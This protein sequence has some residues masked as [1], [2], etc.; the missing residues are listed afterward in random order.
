MLLQ[1]KIS[2]N[3]EKCSGRPV[4]SA[5]VCAGDK[6]D[7]LDL[8]FNWLISSKLFLEDGINQNIDSCSGIWEFTI[9]WSGLTVKF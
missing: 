6:P 9:L 8:H 2:A 5:V 1:V 3:E 4:R 7:S